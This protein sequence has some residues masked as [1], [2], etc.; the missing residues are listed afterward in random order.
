MGKFQKIENLELIQQKLEIKKHQAL[1]S[2]MENNAADPMDIIKADQYLKKIAGGENRKSHIID[3]FQF[4]NQIGFK[5]KPIAMSYKLLRNMSKTP[6]VNSIIKTRINQICNF[7]EPQRDKY[8]T[9][10]VIRKKRYPGMTDDDV[11]NLS[12]EEEKEIY[13]ITDFMQNCGV[14]KGWDSGDFDSFVRKVVRD[15]LTFDQYAFE[16]IHDNKKRPHSFFS[17]DGAT[18][19]IADSLDDEWYEK[20]LEKRGGGRY[21]KKDKI[22]GYYPSYVQIF[23]N[24]IYAEYYPWELCLGIRNATSDIYQNGYGVSELEEMT[25]IITSMLWSD[26]Y[27]R[28]FFKQGSMPKGFIRYQG[29]LNNNRLS[30]F[31]QMWYGTMRGVYNAWKTPIIEAD[32]V[33]W[34][35]LQKNNRDM[36]FVH[37]IEYLIKLACAIFVIDPAEVNFP[38]QGSSNESSLFQGNNEFKIKHSK[39]RGLK[40]ILRHLQKKINKYIISQINEKYEFLFVGID[41]LTREQE[42]DEQIKL[43][44]NIYTIDEVRAMRGLEALPDGMGEVILDASIINAKAQAEM[45][46]GGEEGTE[47]EDDENFLSDEEGDDIGDENF[48]DDEEDTIKAHGYLD[49]EK[50]WDSFISSLKKS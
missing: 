8:S 22:N 43:V 12:K 39:D 23:N 37:W 38:L 17:V 16:V 33:D 42:I 27:N 19:R 35:D 41:D 25:H 6:I 5:D 49:I 11:T 50:N 28:N 2:I 14:N 45:M 18:I 15:S 20:E 3:P 32:K 4:Q 21:S 24:E 10:Y 26:E 13:E 34:V 29:N 36:E 9:G 44:K 46:G 30:E 40:P 31:K 47:G 7:S 1:S 48:L